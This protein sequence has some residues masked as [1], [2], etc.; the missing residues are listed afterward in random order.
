MTDQT[1]AVE[2]ADLKGDIR[3]LNSQITEGMG[4][5][6][7]QLEAVSK[8]VSAMSKLTEEVARHQMAMESQGA[9]LER[10]FAAIEQQRM[11]F[12]EWR[13]AHVKDNNFV[14]RS[15]TRAQGAVVGFALLLGVACTV[16]GILANQWMARTADD[17]KTNRT[18]I[19]RVDHDHDAR[20]DAI[21]RAR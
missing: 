3:V 7:V 21:E 20:L 10:A 13:E 17:I 1:F 2:L 6:R 5:M 11:D 4:G 15:V 9:G 12:A 14:A 16:L 8:Q 19:Q 18:S